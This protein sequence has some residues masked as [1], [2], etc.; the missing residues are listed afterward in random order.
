MNC[1][2]FVDFLMAYLDEELSAPE[3]GRFEEHLAECPS[4]VAYLATYREA[5]RLGKA[6]CG[7]GHD[8][9]PPEVPQELVEAVLSARRAVPGTTKDLEPRP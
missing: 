7:D 3:R 4:C 2:D 1:R 8:A 6:A 9:I 5:V